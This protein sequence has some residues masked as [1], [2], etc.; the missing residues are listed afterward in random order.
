MGK[1][2]NIV[3]QNWKVLAYVNLGVGFM[4]GLIIGLC[5]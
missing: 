2:E 5:F 4:S 1:I 3:I